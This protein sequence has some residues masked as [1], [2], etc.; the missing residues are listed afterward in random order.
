MTGG[1]SLAETPVGQAAVVKRTLVVA[2][3]GGG[4]WSPGP[5]LAG[6]A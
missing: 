1:D 3:R 4:G 6:Q 5:D 2:G